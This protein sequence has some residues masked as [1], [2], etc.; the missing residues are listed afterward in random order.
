MG[1][2]SPI[3]T[4][5]WNK[6]IRHQEALGH[7]GVAGQTWE[8][9]PCGGTYRIE[10]TRIQDSHDTAT[11]CQEA[12]LFGRGSMGSRWKRNGAASWGGPVVNSD[13][14]GGQIWTDDLRVM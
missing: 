10:K 5:W 1:D 8:R 11:W 14:C 3:A 12:A 7:Q 9:G 4:P 6:A 13:G 2:S